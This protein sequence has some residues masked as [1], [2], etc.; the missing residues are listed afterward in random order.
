[1]VGGS[2]PGDA[3]HPVVREAMREV[4][5]DLSAVAPRRLDEAQVR[6]ADVV[7]TMGCGDA[8]P[9]FPGKRY[10][11][12]KVQDPKGLLL[13]QVR[14]IRDDVRDRVRRLLDDLLGGPAAR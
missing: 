1:M 14:A 3:V 13:E 6:A 9:F 7:V 12:W 8:C 10:E 5:I 2:A 4:G 11:D